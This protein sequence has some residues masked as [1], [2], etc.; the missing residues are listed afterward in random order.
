LVAG[1]AGLGQ[2]DNYFGLVRYTKNGKPDN[3]FGIEGKVISIW[4]Y[5]ISILFKK[6]G[7]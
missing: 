6:M 4:G 1:E 2:S 3:S 5:A 7:R